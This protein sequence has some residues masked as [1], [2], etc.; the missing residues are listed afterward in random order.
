MSIRVGKQD[1]DTRLLHDVLIFDTRS[2]NGD[3]T[4]TVADSGY[5]KMS[6][7]KNYLYVTLFEG[8][9]Y[10]QTRGAQWYDRNGLRHHLFERGRTAP[11]LCP[12]CRR[13]TS[14]T[15]PTRRRLATCRSCRC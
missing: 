12:T 6:D 13:A 9:T 1:D 7:D 3:M 11:Y 5:I 10:E 14:P 8:E 2:S 15:A 4:T